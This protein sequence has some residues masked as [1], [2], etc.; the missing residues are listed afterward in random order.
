MNNVR[1]GQLQVGQARNVLA[2]PLANGRHRTLHI[3]QF[4]IGLRHLGQ[5]LFS[6]HRRREGTGEHA[7]LAADPAHLVELRPARLAGAAREEQVGRSSAA[8]SPRPFPGRRR[9]GIVR[10]PGLFAAA[11]RQRFAPLGVSQVEVAA[12]A[13]LECFG[14]PDV[15][16]EHG[17]EAAVTGLCGDAVQCG[18]VA[19]GGGGVS[20]AQ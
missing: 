17:R 14:W 19:G 15:A 18:A 8:S 11:G 6:G 20:G 3:A 16:V 13:G 12:G 7:A 5:D 9:D 1:V 10:A 2:K 4:G